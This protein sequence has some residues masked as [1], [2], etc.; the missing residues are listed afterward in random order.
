[1]DEKKTFEMTAFLGLGGERLDELGEKAVGLG[2]TVEEIQELAQLAAASAAV[3]ELAG[4]PDA[5]LID[6]YDSFGATWLEQL[7]VEE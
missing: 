5:T 2:M 7:G 6:L 4:N 3:L 1:M